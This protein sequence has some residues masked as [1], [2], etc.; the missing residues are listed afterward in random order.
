M[1]LAAPKLDDRHFQD[2][3]D[4][5]KKR[6]PY[7]IEEWTDHNV[8]DPGVTMIELFAWMTDTI[9]YR[10]NQVPDLH[11]IKFMEL[12][13]MNLR[14]PVPARAMVTFWLSA[15]QDMAVLIPEGTEVASTQTETQPSIIFTTDQNL[16][17]RPP[18]LKAAQ[19]Y[20]V[21]ADNEREYRRFDADP[22]IKGLETV[23]VFSSVPRE[24]DAFYFG[25]DN[26]LSS[27]ILG[28][29]LDCD[30]TG[31]S[32]IDPTQPPTI[33]EASTGS[34]ERPWQPCEVDLGEDSTK[35]LNVAG[36]IRM[37]LPPMGRYSVNN[38][39]LFWVRVR[40]LHQDEYTPRMKPYRTTPRLRQTA[41]SSWGATTTV[42]HSQLI[43]KEFLSQSDGSPGQKFQLQV[44]PILQ[45]RPNETLIV[46]VGEEIQ[47]WKEVANFAESSGEDQCFTL[48]SITGELRLGPAIRQPDG[49]MRQYGAIPPRGAQVVFQRYRYGGGLEGNVQ[50]NIINTLKTAIPFI[51]RVVNRR[52]AVGGLDAESME[53]AKMR[54]PALLRSRDRAV[55]EADFEFLAR[56][57]LRYTGWDQYRVHCLQPV[58]SRESRIIPGQVYLLIIPHIQD[59]EQRLRP[60]A[61][62]LQLKQDEVYHHLSAY[63]NQRRL[64][65]IRLDIREPV[66]YWVSARVSVRALP[67]ANH[68]DAET[69]VLNRL[70]QF[71]NPIVGGRDGKGWPFG[72]DL[73]IS[74]LHQCLQGVPGVQFIRNVEMFVT[75]AGEGPR[76][77]PVETVDLVGHGV[78]ASGIHEVVFS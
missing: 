51:D 1:P 7:Y 74:D 43:K 60:M 54:A 49:T 47:T 67:G 32:G 33:W 77:D 41:V 24:G 68:A 8:S 25:F 61:D 62:Q 11:Y 40:L 75:A 22:L 2:I 66:Y 37:H 72:R 53:A 73:V 55:T 19:A 12:L 65:T 27:H 50:A 9:L 30:P 31:G 28:L 78:I 57:A 20:L 70:Y 17:I 38:E 21:N 58:P 18:R 42:T 3:V 26:D 76:G 6:I 10:L 23:E 14:E 4:E 35:G 45:R 63:L 36:R 44:T 48:D 59:P 29:N 52:A 46:Q 64:L 69:M 71:L 16:V 13:G 34:Q 39:S 15:P 56:E 5:A